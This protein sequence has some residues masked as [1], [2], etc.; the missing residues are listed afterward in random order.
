MSARDLSDLDPIETL[1]WLDALSAVRE[2]RGPEDD[3]L[4]HRILDDYQNVELRPRL[5][6]WI[7]RVND[8]PRA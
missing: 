1:E 7:K 8:R 4:F 2:H 3:E 6:A 5:A